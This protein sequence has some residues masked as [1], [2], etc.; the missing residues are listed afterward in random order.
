[1]YDDVD[2]DNQLQQAK[3]SRHPWTSP[4][5]APAF[6]NGCGAAGGSPLGCLCQE[7]GVNF[8]YGEDD[9]PYGSCCGAPDENVR[10][11]YVVAPQTKHPDGLLDFVSFDLECCA[12]LVVIQQLG[13]LPESHLPMQTLAKMN[14]VNQT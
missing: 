12:W 10:M 5:T 7:D 11:L 9:R 2:T 4:G 1:M 3:D 6:G 13:Q 8:C 14:K